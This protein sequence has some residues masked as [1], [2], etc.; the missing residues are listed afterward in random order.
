MITRLGIGEALVTGL[1]EK[2]EPT[3]LVHTLMAP[4]QSRMD[5]ITEAEMTQTIAASGLAAKYEKTLDP[6]SAY[7]MLSGKLSQSAQPQDA[8]SSPAARPAPAS[9][10]SEANTAAVKYM[11]S[12]GKSVATSL[13][14]NL[15]GQITRSVLG[16]IMGP[17]RR[18]RY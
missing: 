18:R 4:P 1:G 9:K 15:T 14:R 6:Q 17:P 11:Q 2:G 8:P 10:P 13:V 3:P 5:T 7:E 12:L 16:A